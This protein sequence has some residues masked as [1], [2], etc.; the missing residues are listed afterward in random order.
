MLILLLQVNGGPTTTRQGMI[1]PLTRP[2]QHLHFVFLFQ[3]F[4]CSLA[5]LLGIIE[6]SVQRTLSQKSCPSSRCSFANLDPAA[7]LF[8]EGRGFLLQPFID[9]RTMEF[10]WF[11]DDLIRLKD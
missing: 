2:V 4:C 7:I 11:G 3:P 9:G 8:L 6:S 10:R 5:A 1:W